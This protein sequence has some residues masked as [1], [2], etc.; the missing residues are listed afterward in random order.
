MLVSLQ[1]SAGALPAPRQV[2]RRQRE[3]PVPA[4]IIRMGADFA[5]ATI[6]VVPAYWLRF[7][8]FPVPIPGGQAPGLSQYLY[9]S[10]GLAGC[11]VL[12]LALTGNYGTDRGV[13]FVDELFDALRAVAAVTV[14]LFAAI[15][16]DPSQNY[17]RL[18]LVLWLGCGSLLIGCARYAIRKLEKHQRTRGIG[19]VRALIVGG[20]AAA[21]RLAQRIRM[22]PDFGYEL[23]GVL[24][25]DHAGALVSGGDVIGPIAQLSSAIHERQI[26]VVFVALPYVEHERLGELVAANRDAQVEFRIVPTTIELVASRVEPDH[27]AGIPL[28]RV[29]RSRESVPAL[30]ASKR[31]FDGTVA[32]AALVLLSPVLVIIALIIKMTSRGPLLI[33]QERVGLNN[34]TFKMFKFRSMRTN[35]E[36]AS[37][38]VW[39]SAHDDRRTAIGRLLR[40]FSLDELPQFWNVLR[41]DMSLVGPRPERRKF[42][43]EFSAHIPMYADRLRVRPGLTGWAQVN[44]LRGMTSVEDRLVYDLFYIERWTLTFDLKIVVTT[45]FRIFTSKNA[46]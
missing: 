39:A 25:D 32:S 36:A 46:Y 26:D 7:R 4:F 1:E 12:A 10:P 45:A 24:T 19:A 20:G 18:T 42:V 15:T 38:P 5:M 33:T 40:R 29:R 14:V 3:F 9:A 2:V 17:S 41:G 35:A 37:G 28:L 27:L 43:D 22:F 31:L 21:S 13:L 23:V 34:C 30:A 8:V 6:A 44:D 16:I 11:L